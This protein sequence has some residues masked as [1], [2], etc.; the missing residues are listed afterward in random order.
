MFK[1]EILTGHFLLS[2]F[3]LLP[4]S[5]ARFI[6]GPSMAYRRGPGIAAL[7]FAI[8]PCEKWEGKR[9]TEAD[10]PVFGRA[11]G[12]I[13]GPCSPQI[14]LCGRKALT[15]FFCGAGALLQDKSVCP[16]R[17]EIRIKTVALKQGP[18]AFCCPVY[19]FIAMSQ[20]PQMTLRRFPTFLQS[21]S[22]WIFL[23]AS[24]IGAGR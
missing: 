10:P 7:F 17:G 14:L 22:R 1:L 5:V 8:S 15:W 24:A 21:P 11:T 9:E 16:K 6:T 18:C 3:P 19:S 13:K 4:G 20:A 2:S 12:T 23:P